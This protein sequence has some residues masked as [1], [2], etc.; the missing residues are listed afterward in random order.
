MKDVNKA[1]VM[2]DKKEVIAHAK[3]YYKAE[4]LSPQGYNRGCIS[5]DVFHILVGHDCYQIV[6]ELITDYEGSVVFVYNPGTEM[7]RYCEYE[8]PVGYCNWCKNPMFHLEQAVG[9]IE[10]KLI[11]ET[12]WEIGKHLPQEESYHD[13]MVRLGMREDY[14]RHPITGF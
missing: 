8:G 9:E 13:A 2:S 3:K 6:D 4:V 7:F 11:C 10:D 5:D 1:V 14:T 12:C